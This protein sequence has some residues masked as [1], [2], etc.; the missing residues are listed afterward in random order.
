MLTRRAPIPR[1]P[2]TAPR[3]DREPPVPL[4]RLSIT[5]RKVG[6]AR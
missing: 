4:H 2:R 6:T 1:A 5:Q 3:P